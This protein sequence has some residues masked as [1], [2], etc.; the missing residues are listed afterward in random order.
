[1]IGGLIDRALYALIRALPI[2]AASALG[3]ALS[4]V[5]GR[6]KSPLAHQRARALLAALNPAWGR[7]E[8]A[9]EAAMGRLW[10]GIGRTHA[11][12][13]HLA[14]IILGGRM[15][16]EGEAG[17]EAVLAGPRPVIF[18]FVHLGNW[19]ATAGHVAV[20]APGRAVAIYQPPAQASRR[21]LAER[22]R[23]PAPMRMVPMGPQVWRQALAQLSRPGGLLIVAGDEVADRRVGAPFFWREPF[24]D[25]N[26]GKVSRLAMR[27]GALVMPIW[28]ERLPG[29]RF[30]G[31]FMEPVEITGD[32]RDAEA[33][34]AA[35]LRLNALI[36]PPI[37]AHL[38]Q[39][40]MALEL[41]EPPPG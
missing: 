7:D 34:R 31:H 41:R 24:L 23:A 29:A 8:A 30:V 27:T 5:M 4:G 25:G 18:L 1:M 12:F 39:W 21:A 20:R 28:N 14:T 17:L 16:L 13:A 2:E 33:V 26:L 40:F 11:E 36:T 22:A 19:E 37:L 32:P 3:E 38:D 35:V 6:R 15:R 9:L 10:G